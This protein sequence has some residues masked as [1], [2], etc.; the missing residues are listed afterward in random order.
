[1]HKGA[2]IASA[3][4]GGQV[5]VSD[6]T[7]E[8]VG[9]EL[10]GGAT[11]LNLGEHRLKD[12]PK[13]E[14]IFQL[15][16]P[17]LPADFPPI[18][19][20]GRNN[21]PTHLTPF[22]GRAP[23]LDRAQA[24]LME[25]R[26]VTLTG[27]GGTGK[28]RFAI[29]TAS[30]VRYEFLDG[31]F[32]VALAPITNPDLVA[33]AIADTLGI[34]LDP[35][36]PAVDAVKADLAIKDMLLVLDNLEQVL[37]AASTIS[38]LLR[39]TTLLKVLA[40]SRE[41]LHISGEQEFP[42]PP[43]A[44]PEPD[45]APTPE[46]IEQYEAVALF[47]QRAR[48][49]RPEFRL[50]ADNASAIARITSRLDGLPLAIELA[51]SRIKVLSP[52]GIL[53]RLENSLTLLATK[54]ADLPSRQQTLRGTIAWSHD[55]L[56]EEERVLFHRLSVFV[57]S[58]TVA[59]AEAVVADG[60][61]VDVLDGVASLLDKN[62]LRSGEHERGEERFQMLGTIR[63]FALEQMRES[64]ELESITATHAA[65]FADWTQRQW[66]HLTLAEHEATAEQMV[67]EIENIR[68]AWR[69]WVAKEDLA[70]LGKL[71]DSLWLLY[72]QRGWYHDT[73][74]LAS[75]LLNVLSLTPSTPERMLE[76]ITLQTSLARVLF[77]IKG[78]T[79]EVEDA[80]T[81]A[82][83]FCEGREDVPQV[84][85][86]LQALAG[87]CIYRGE[88]EKAERIGEQLLRFADRHDD[89]SVRAEAHVTLGS[90][91]IFLN[92]LESGLEHLEKGI[93]AF[94]LQPPGAGRFRQGNNRGV[95]CQMT[96]AL[97][98]WMLGFP[99]RA[100]DRANDAT[101]LAKQL[102]HPPSTT[103]ALFHT[104]LIH[105]W[106]REPELAHGC[107]QAV[108]DM[109]ERHDLPMW[110]AVGS[111]LLGAALGGM[112]SA[113]EGLAL[114][115]SGMSAYQ[116]LQTPPVFWPIL[117]YL[118]GA[119]CGLAGRPGEG[120]KLAEEGMAMALSGPSKTL[121]SN[122]F[123]LQGN[124]LL[125][126][127]PDDT[128]EAESWFQKAVDAAAES[129]ALMLELRAALRL[130]RLWRE[131]GKIEDAREL[132]SDVYGRFTEGFAIADLS[133]AKALLEDL[134][135]SS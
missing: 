65:Y 92:R 14:R 1:V 69:Y 70:Q 39:A 91:S 118:R 20:V 106:R 45:G 24:H 98:L 9:E 33:V 41:A 90:A 67:D 71:T 10:E 58:F 36:R 12:F 38:D 46:A 127:S 114:I 47:V 59:A 123:E 129:H 121:W 66:Q 105:V 103:Y 82:L 54:S 44:T 63:E 80:Y 75:D 42:V 48:A 55:L 2:R 28:T 104:G 93:A 11:L 16:A 53:S 62:L 56:T 130:S 57:R 100:R 94:N 18:R 17:G 120:L 111:C 22:I 64:G 133:E 107:A 29:E 119:A 31:V 23:E 32:F 49:A 15:R 79:E 52:E 128:T 109:A 86:V 89:S 95:A 117:L 25:R 40:T 126:L 43:L 4:H 108:L 134:T 87:F 73:V 81:K 135:R 78:Y 19:A 35:S 113:D 77:T 34:K 131:Q 124:L 88:F 76:Q 110:K 96:S 26:L 101:A 72:Y 30:R 115:E 60:A 112:G 83:E 68:A 21:L 3:G 97:V 51:A 13:D 27:P 125:I 50:S 116:R 61:E 122:Y 6:R 74:S 7:R 8:V 84:L 102:N 37:P 85:P 99:D 5:L 132:L